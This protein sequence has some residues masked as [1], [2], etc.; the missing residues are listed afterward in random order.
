[1]AHGVHRPRLE[2]EALASELLFGADIKDVI[3]VLI[4]DVA[5]NA[6]SATNQVKLGGE[7]GVAIGPVGREMEGSFNVSG[8]GSGVVLSYTFSKGLFGG[9]GMEGAF[10]RGRV[11]EVSG[12]NFG[13]PTV[14]GVLHTSTWTAS[15]IFLMHIKNRHTNRSDSLLAAH[16]SQL[17]FTH[18][19]YIMHPQNEK[20]YSQPA[21]PQEILFGDIVQAPEGKGIQDLHDKLEMM[22]RGETR[23][24]TEE[25]SKKKEELRVEAEEAGKAAKAEQ[26]NDVEHIDAEA[27][28]TK[29]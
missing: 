4:D 1:M 24:P 6:M 9:V 27:M 5:V 11:G 19:H 17:Y 15:C 10:I 3:L 7:V 12:V 14:E 23:V 8:K 21:T 20:F 22:R 28:A 18:F 13:I 25:E 26:G 29:E 2:W 16:T